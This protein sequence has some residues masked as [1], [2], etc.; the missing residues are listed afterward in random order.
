MSASPSK[1]TV[2]NNG[3]NYYYAPSVGMMNDG[4]GSNHTWEDG[5]NT[6]NI[7]YYGSA[8][9]N[10][11]DIGDRDSS[12]NVIPWRIIGVFKNMKLAD[13][14]TDTLV[15]VIRD[16]TI[17]DMTWNNDSESSNDWSTA[18]LKTYLNEG[19]YY[20]GLS[21]HVKDKI[22]MVEWNL[23]GY[24]STL[25][26]AND[27]YKYER[28]ELKADNSF[29]TIWTGNIA[30]MYPSDYGYSADLTKCTETLSSYSADT[31]NCTGTDWLYSGSDEWLFVPNSSNSSNVFRLAASG[32]IS[33]TAA[34]SV[35][36]FYKFRPTLYL[37]SD[38]VMKW[39]DGTSANRAYV[40]G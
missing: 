28:G 40:V 36:T 35:S 26:Y 9:A 8:P 11:I 18:S 25:I 10:Y 7:R 31:T 20:T 30:L 14:T 22:A 23:G 12:G 19:G 2:A 13:G 5:A 33:H 34:P 16:E 1:A 21:Q 24:D 27:I 37:K 32:W 17:G 39:G 6:G 4:M 38:L 29:K 3:I 15:K